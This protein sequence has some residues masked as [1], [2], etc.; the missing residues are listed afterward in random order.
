VLR[1]GLTG[2]ALL[3][4]LGVVAS[5]LAAQRPSNAASMS[6]RE[7]IQ[8]AIQEAEKIVA[9]PGYSGRLKQIKRREITL[10]QQRL[11]EGDLQP[12]DQIFITVMGEAALNNPNFIVTVDRSL[13]LPT[14]GEISLKGVLRS[15]VEG[16]LTQEVG[17]Y[18]KDPKIHA[19]TSIRLSFLGAIGKPGFYQLRSETMI[20]DAIMEAGGPAG[21]IDPAKTRVERGGR[22]IL[23]QEAF[24]EA[25]NRGKTLDQ[26]SLRAGDEIIVGGN[27]TNRQ[28]GNSA[29][30]I[31]VPVISSIAGLGYLFAQIF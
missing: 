13:I 5:S 25:L 10:L 14:F 31:I 3:G 2:F 6:S 19:S 26:M 18:L 15:E 16:Y 1:T 27:R 28:G 20:G 23:S 24:V 12:G 29:W 8:V 4:C 21:N 17:R 22:E 11:E 30:N 7:E 9:S